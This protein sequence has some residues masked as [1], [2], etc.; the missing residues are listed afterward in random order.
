MSQGRA[1]RYAALLG[2]M[3]GA[4]DPAASCDEDPQAQRLD[5]RIEIMVDGATRLAEVAD[6]AVERDRGWRHRQCGRD[7]LLLVPDD[8]MPVPIWGCALSSPVDLLFVRDA[9]IVEVVRELS[10]C[11]EPCSQ[12]PIVGEGIEVEAV[13]EMPHDPDAALAS[14]SL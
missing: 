13:V 12:C 9:E 1:G 3:V 2:A 10:P 14:V 6:D 8:V 4:C 7:A 5:E 11:P